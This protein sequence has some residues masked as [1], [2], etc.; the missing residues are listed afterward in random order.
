MAIHNYYLLLGL[1]DILVNNCEEPP[2]SRL[3]RR[4]DPVFVDALKT[5][6]KEN[7]TG[8]GIPP[9]AVACKDVRTKELFQERLK[10]VY[11]YEVHGGVHGIKARQV[12]NS[13]G[14]MLKVVACHV[15]A[16]LTDEE[17]L[18]L[19]SRHNANGHFHHNMTHRDYAS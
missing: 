17:S 2:A 16:G 11:R 15:Y 14:S 3:R 19:A 6:L 4:V 12:L 8:I 13:E 5:R 7:S 10:D 1:L 9:L 18:W